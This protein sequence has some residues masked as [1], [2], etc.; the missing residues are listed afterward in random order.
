ALAQTGY[1][2]EEERRVTTSRE[3]DRPV[4]K[5]YGPDALTGLAGQ[6]IRE[7]RSDVTVET[8]YKPLKNKVFIEGTSGS[9]YMPLSPKRVDRMEAARA[10]GGSVY[11]ALC[12]E[13]KGVIRKT[14]GGDK[15][16]VRLER[17]KTRVTRYVRTIC[18]P[19]PAVFVPAVRVGVLVGGPCVTV[20]PPYPVYGYRAYGAW[21][22][23]RDHYY[24]EGRGYYP[25]HGGH[26][27]P[28]HGP[29][30]FHR[31]RR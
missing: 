27:P 3:A 10:K 12:T 22:V 24:H 25:S 7:Q 28:P 29:G 4:V 18:P 30:S 20:G 9:D 14:V 26:G 23:H 2:V 8:Y 21:G 5:V 1:R 17:K 19:P 6:A 31:D 16:W 13:Q 15:G 11:A